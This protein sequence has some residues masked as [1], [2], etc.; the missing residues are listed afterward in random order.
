MVHT[1]NIVVRKV[2]NHDFE[3]G[4][5]SVLQQLNP[6][7]S[8]VTREMYCA[9]L[10]ERNNRGDITMVAVDLTTNRIIGSVSGD[11]LLK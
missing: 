1:N 8:N 3:L 7:T 5:L 6:T 4:H 11:L 10:N 2:N 9:R